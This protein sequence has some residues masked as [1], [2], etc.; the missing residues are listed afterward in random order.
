MLQWLVVLQQAVANIS[1]KN[2]LRLGSTIAGVMDTFILCVS[3][4]SNTMTIHAA[5][6]IRE[7]F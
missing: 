3:P 6:D 2:A 4:L 7:L 1:A 5:M